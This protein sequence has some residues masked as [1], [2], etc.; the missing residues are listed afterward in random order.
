[1][2]TRPDDL[3]G[4]FGLG[5][6]FESLTEE[7]RTMRSILADKLKDQGRSLLGEVKDYRSE[8]KD[9]TYGQAIRALFER[10]EEKE[11]S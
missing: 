11:L 10:E 5:E 9:S 7:E 6:G 8:H 4:A 1:M 2:E 3:L